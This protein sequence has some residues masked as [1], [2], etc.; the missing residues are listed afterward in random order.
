MSNLCT[1]TRVLE[2]PTEE[3]SASY[4]YYISS[5]YAAGTSNQPLLAS[6]STSASTAVH[7]TLR[8]HK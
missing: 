8:Y 1:I 4:M 6:Q 2:L 5:T 3:P 7:V